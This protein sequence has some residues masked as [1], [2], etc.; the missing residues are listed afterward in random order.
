VDVKAR[1]GVRIFSQGDASTMIFY[2]RRGLVVSH[3]E[4]RN[5]RGLHVFHANAGEFV[6]LSALLEGFA[7]AASGI[8]QTATQ[9]LR[10][11]SATLRKLVARDSMLSSYFLNR[12]LGRLIE[13]TEQLKN[14][15]LMDASARVAKLLL[16][17]SESGASNAQ[18]VGFEVSDRMIGLSASGVSRETVNRKLR[19]FIERGLIE[20]RGKKIRLLDVATLRAISEGEHSGHLSG[21]EG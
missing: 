20:R 19:S 9:L 12:T 2:V 16:Q 11:E 14:L 1:Q 21:Q 8:A 3:A 10:F 17:F 15:A 4:S 6:P 18:S 13:R 7:Y 5:G